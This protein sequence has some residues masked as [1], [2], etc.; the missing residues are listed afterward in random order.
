MLEGFLKQQ[1]DSGFY[2]ECSILKR[3]F[4]LLVKIRFSRGTMAEAAIQWQKQ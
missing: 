4:R 3:S 1:R 2:P